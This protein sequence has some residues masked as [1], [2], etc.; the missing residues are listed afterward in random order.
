MQIWWIRRDLR[1]KDNPALSAAMRDGSDA[2]PVVVLDEYL[3]AK[4]AEKRQA[5]FISGLRAAGERPA[6]PGFRAG[7]APRRPGYGAAAPVHE[8]GAGA[9]FAE[10]DVSP[11]ALQRDASVARAGRPAPGARPGSSPHRCRNAPRWKT[12]HCIH[13]VQL[14]LEKPALQRAHATSPHRPAA[15]PQPAHRCPARPGQPAH[16]SSG[17]EEA[18]AALEAFLDGPIFAYGEGRNQLDY[19]G[20]YS[21]LSPYLRFGMLSARSVAAAARQAAAQSLRRSFA[22]RLRDLAERIDLA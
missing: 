15:H 21:T 5:F 10:E 7:R 13:P 6:P 20:I 18:C 22:C 4:P 16:L 14:R 8:F 3:L 12:I 2:L 9:V 17:E 1:L 19:I 11:Y